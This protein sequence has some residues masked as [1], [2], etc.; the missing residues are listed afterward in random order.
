MLRL[1][2]AEWE[3][4]NTTTRVKKLLVLETADGE[5]E[6]EDGYRLANVRDD[7][8]NEFGELGLICTLGA[9]SR[10]SSLTRSSE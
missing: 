3:G 10:M 8:C 1:E 4:G 9:I 2:G 5:E 6:C 7:S